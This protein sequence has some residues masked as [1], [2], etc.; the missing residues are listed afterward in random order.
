MHLHF[1]FIFFTAP[2]CFAVALSFV[3]GFSIFLFFFKA[4]SNG[5]IQTHLVYLCTQLIESAGGP[6][7]NADLAEALFHSDDTSSEVTL[8]W[9]DPDLV[10]WECKTAYRWEVQHRPDIG[11]IK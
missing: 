1:Y 11:V 2:L 5:F 9:H 8:L 10:G 4:V 6:A 7:A 3:A